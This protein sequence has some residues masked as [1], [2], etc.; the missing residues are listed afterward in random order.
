M[1]RTTKRLSGRI[2]TVAD[3]VTVGYRER[4]TNRQMADEFIEDTWRNAIHN[5]DPL[6]RLKYKDHILDRAI[7]KPAQAV[8]VTSNGE[9]IDNAP[10]IINVINQA[11]ADALGKLSEIK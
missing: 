6:V 10:R 9:N 7:G 1:D 8:D 11:T 2:K 3:M 5:P 4:L